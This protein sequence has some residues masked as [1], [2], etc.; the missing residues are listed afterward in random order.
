MFGKYKGIEFGISL[1]RVLDYGAVS[2]RDEWTI[3]I[4]GEH[5]SPGSLNPVTWSFNGFEQA[6]KRH[7]DNLFGLAYNAV[8]GRVDELAGTP[9]VPQ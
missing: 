3:T 8:D 6:I 1:E 5:V 2:V 4:G 7:V 9:P